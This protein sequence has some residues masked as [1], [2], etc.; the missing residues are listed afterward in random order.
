[1]TVLFHAKVLELLKMQTDNHH[2]INKELL[3]DGWMDNKS[4]GDGHGH[5]Q[6]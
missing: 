1:M 6:I 5:G 4:V 3:M 2:F